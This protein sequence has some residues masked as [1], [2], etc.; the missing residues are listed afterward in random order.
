MTIKK[1]KKKK[2]RPR[3]EEN[4][5]QVY[6]CIYWWLGINMTHIFCFLRKIVA[7]WLFNDLLYKHRYI[8]FPPILFPPISYIRE[9]ITRRELF[10]ARQL[11]AECNERGERKREE[12]KK[13]KKRDRK[14]KKGIKI[15]TGEGGA[16]IFSKTNCINART[17]SSGTNYFGSFQATRRIFSGHA[18]SYFSRNAFARRGHANSDLHNVWIMHTPLTVTNASNYRNAPID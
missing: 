12:K 3:I 11:I 7:R 13:W 2:F 16:R 15:N 5:K 18:L 17:A 4:L 10:F 6:T 8:T 14:E 1:K 9:T